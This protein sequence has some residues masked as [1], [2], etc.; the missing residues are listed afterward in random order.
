MHTPASARSAFTSSAAAAFE[1]AATSS[2]SGR[3]V[4]SHSRTCAAAIGKPATV[5]TSPAAVPGRTAMVKDTGSTVSAK[6][7]NGAPTARV[8][9]VGTTGPSSELSIGT[10]A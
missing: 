7:C 6:I 9:S 8:S 4:A 1:F 5:F 2:A 3:L 10:H